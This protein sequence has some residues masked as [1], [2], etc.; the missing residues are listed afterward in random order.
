MEYKEI[1]KLILSKDKAGLE[2]LYNIYGQKFYSFAVTRWNLSE[3]DAWEVVYQTLETLVLKLPDYMFESKLHFDNF[4]FKVFTNFLRQLYRKHRHREV[5]KYGTEKLFDD[6]IYSDSQEVTEILDIENRESYESS[7]FSI[8]HQVLN[9]YY[10][11]E[12]VENPKLTA[13]RKAL[14]QLDEVER[15]ILLLRAQDYS[16]DEIAKMLKIDNKQLKVRHHRIKSRLI[17]IMTKN[18]LTNEQK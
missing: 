9:E 7:D 2:A 10:E 4:L 6:S 3:D 5:E 1:I 14:E 8:E 12:I 15:D 11:T 13:L 18:T 16:Y 17:L